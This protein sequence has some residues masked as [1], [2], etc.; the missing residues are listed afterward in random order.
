M[1]GGRLLEAAPNLPLM[2]LTV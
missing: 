2:E 1:R